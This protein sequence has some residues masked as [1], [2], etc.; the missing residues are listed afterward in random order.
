MPHDPDPQIE[1]RERLAQARTEIERAIASGAD[2]DAEFARWRERFAELEPELSQLEHHL[3]GRL[4][5][6]AVPREPQG[7]PAEPSGAGTLPLSPS[8]T[9]TFPGSVG[10]TVP[11]TSAKQ[12]I[13]GGS[14]LPQS[15]ETG[16]YESGAPGSADSVG[17][18]HVPHPGRRSPDA[19]ATT[20]GGSAV[21]SSGGNHESPLPPGHRIR[22]IGDYELRAV[23]GRGGMGVVYRAHQLSLNRPVAL[24]MIRNA[25]FSDENQLRRFQN[26]AE[27]VAM[28]DH[29]GIVP[30]YEV[31]QFEDER[32]FS[33][34]LIEGD[35]LA[36]QLESFSKNP[37][38]A[39][40]LMSEAASAVHHAHERGILHR[41][42]KPANILVD[43]QGQPHV[44]DFGLAKKIEGDSGLTVSGTILGTPA[45]MA[46]EQAT[47]RTGQ[48]TVATDV[49]GLGATLYALL[50]GK[51]PFKGDSVLET[52]EH[53]RRDPPQA[54]T[55]V[56]ARVP[57]D[58]EVICLTCLGKDPKL[59]Y[60]SAAA[61]AG[62]LD[63]WLAG[64]P[65]SARPVSTAMRAWMW[66]K[67]KPALAGLTAALVLALVVGVV[68]MSWQWR[69]AVYQRNQ[70]VDARDLARREEQAAR[71][72]E[73]D[74]RAARDA[75]VASEKSAQA[76]R[77]E[78]EQNAMIA[79]QQAT[80]ALN[81]IQDMIVQAS[82]GL[83]GPGLFDVKKSLLDLALKRVDLV[84]NGYD[85]F[86][87]K[88]ATALRAVMELGK[89]FR[90]LGQSE[91]STQ[92]FEKGLAIARERIV[93]KKGSDASRQN[94][95]LVHSELGTNSQEYRRDMKTA[96]DHQREALRIYEEILE[97]PKPEGFPADPVVIRVA[98]AEAYQRLGAIQ[99]RLGEL[100]AARDN[101]RKAGNI[102]RELSDND[103]SNSML[104]QQLSYSTMALAETSFRLGDR[105]LADEYYRAV[106]DQRKKMAADRPKD[107]QSQKELGDIQYMLG[108]FK[109]RCEDYAAARAFLDQSL[110]VRESLTKTENRN[111]LFK[112][113]VGMSHYRL[114]NL[115]DRQKKTDRALAA[116]R[117]A[118]T[119]R[120]ELERTSESNDRRRMELML[121]LAHTGDVDRAQ[122]MA[123]RLAAG[124]SVDR[125]LRVDLA[126]C[127]AQCARAVPNDKMER[128]Q[129]LFVKAM[130]SLRTAVK[131]GYRD[132]VFVATEPDL[133]SLRD[134]ADF[135][136]LLL[137]LRA[138]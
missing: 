51:A 74:A 99:Y 29:P 27:A 100:V 131:D 137:E 55:R 111:A 6:Q 43:G 103:P 93:I 87:S 107:P 88:E 46:P 68:G 109:L 106:L 91:K 11:S 110:A 37:R 76:A 57:R 65:I 135:Q 118:L 85:K 5:T 79:G 124:P 97:T 67:R 42:L 38:A 138:P 59:R 122:E 105:D 90:L 77:A 75:A 101:F 136:S 31:G 41:D 113:D 9:A 21:G 30:I 94:L 2:A 71:R 130:E 58:L 47:G 39:A 96:L 66:C 24:K 80:L 16:V 112:R 81:T 127:Y 45:Y 108:E 126:R 119:M 50:T 84:A 62:D 129:T 13:A 125:E 44:T 104:K 78:A 34:K 133:D 23:L 52:L 116:Y 28:L 48:I 3:R 128:K 8:E 54:P 89:I 15:D 1:R 123:D 82:E 35:S 83:Q 40:R 86:T 98:I 115:D 121:A 32:Y 22:Y 102:R 56:N 60:G 73:L 95:A 7:V 36:N 12:G 4:S 53:V 10:E 25:E 132:S 63:R 117:T 69:E 114:G 120:E 64:E 20:D 49:Y 92:W 134:R 70:A 19:E 33:M 14:T 18:V 26:E 17:I 72:A 61:L